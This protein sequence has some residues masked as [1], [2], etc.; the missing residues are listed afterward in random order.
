MVTVR[1]N[2]RQLD[3]VWEEAIFRQANAQARAA[4]TNN[5]GPRRQEF[6]WHLSACLGE[7]A[8]ALYLAEEWTGRIGNR[9]D[10]GRHDVGD[11]YEV[12]TTTALGPLRVRYKDQKWPPS[13]VFIL[14]H[15]AFAFEPEPDVEIMGWTTL[16]EAFDQPMKTYG[17]TE[18]FE[19]RYVDLRPIK[20]LIHARQS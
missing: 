14:C 6:Y 8:T 3:E 18:V 15:V 13:T 9:T 4:A 10:Q 12:R 17:E 1:F 2:R 5:P 20:E 19:T 7:V 16:N 11:R